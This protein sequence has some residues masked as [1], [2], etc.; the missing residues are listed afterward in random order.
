MPYSTPIFYLLKHWNSLFNRLGIRWLEFTAFWFDS[1]SAVFTIT[2]CHVTVLWP[3]TPVAQKFTFHEGRGEITT[4]DRQSSV[5]GLSTMFHDDAHKSE[6]LT[7]KVYL[8]L[9]R[10]STSES[11]EN[12]WSSMLMTVFG[13]INAKDLELLGGPG[14]K[15]SRDIEA[16]DT[17]GDAMKAKLIIAGKMSADT[18]AKSFGAGEVTKWAIPKKFINTMRKPGQ[19]WQTD[20]WLPRKCQAMPESSTA[21]QTRSSSR[22]DVNARYYQRPASSLLSDFTV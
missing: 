18:H 16:L 10:T 20:S 4:L 14:P 13:R 1:A 19:G 8:S 17:I 6:C 5:F 11:V 7:Q 3:E 12:I 21:D 22:K 2:P 9:S 15:K